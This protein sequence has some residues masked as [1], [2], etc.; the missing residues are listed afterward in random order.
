MDVVRAQIA[1]EQKK[2]QKKETP[3]AP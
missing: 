2:E 3:P 1:D